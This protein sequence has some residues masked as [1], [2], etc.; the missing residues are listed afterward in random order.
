VLTWPA[1]YG[2]DGVLPPDGDDAFDPDEQDVA[3]IVIRTIPAVTNG[4][5]RTIM[6]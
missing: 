3:A 4:F 5:G 1:A 6:G 2:V